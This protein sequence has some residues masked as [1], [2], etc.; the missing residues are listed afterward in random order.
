MP[1]KGAVQIDEVQPVEPGFGELA[2]LRRGIVVEDGGARHLAADKAHAFAVF[3]VDRRIKDH[4]GRPVVEQLVVVMARN[5]AVFD[6]RIDRMGAPAPIAEAFI[7]PDRR[8]LGI[9]QIEV[10]HGKP[11]FAGEPFDFQHD[12]AAETMA[13]RPRR[14]KGAG[15]CPGKG[16][17]LVVA[18]RAAQLRRPGDDAVEAADHHPTLRDQQHAL[19]IVFENLARRR[20]EP[21]KPAALDNRTLG[22]LAQIIEIG[23]RILGQ[24]FDI[25]PGPDILPVAHGFHRRKLPISCNPAAW[26]FSGWNCVPA[27]LSCPMTAAIGAP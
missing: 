7:Q 8:L 4:G 23:A 10:Q 1:G 5:D 17:G 14:H 6:P 27:R 20:L 15:Q 18:R 24:P 19:P 21:A 22:R 11:Q 26:L 3:K 12:V 2:R 9:A 13:A 16:L 25:D